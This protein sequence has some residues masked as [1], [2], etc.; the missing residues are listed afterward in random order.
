MTLKIPYGK[1]C[2]I[3]CDAPAAKCVWG[4]VW[5]SGINWVWGEVL[6]AAKGM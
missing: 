2:R 5:V 1:E 4:W 3:V 6:S